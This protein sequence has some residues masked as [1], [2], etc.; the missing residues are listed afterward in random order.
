MSEFRRRA[1][2]AVNKLSYDRIEYLESDGINSQYIQL[3]IGVQEGLDI[4]CKFSIVKASY[5]G[6]I[7]GNQESSSNYLIVR[8]SSTSGKIQVALAN[9]SSA[10]ESLLHI[11][12]IR[13]IHIHLWNESQTCLLDDTILLNKTASYNN[14]TNYKINIWHRTVGDYFKSKVRIYSFSVY[15]HNA[16]VLDLVPVKDNGVGYMYDKVSRQL[17]GNSGTGDFIIPGGGIN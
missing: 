10:T 5:Y 7:F 13:D 14:I 11:G 6:Y 8:Q 17:F 3:P 2:I 12:D 1:T 9:N 15:L 16:L 4:Y